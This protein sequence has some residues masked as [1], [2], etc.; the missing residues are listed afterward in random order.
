[1][2]GHEVRDSIPSTHVTS[3]CGAYL[4][5]ALAG[6][7]GRIPWPCWPANEAEAVNFS[8]MKDPSFKNNLRT[9]DEDT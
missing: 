7:G 3:L 8:Y 6:G 5:S 1:M 9:S 4:L 2:P